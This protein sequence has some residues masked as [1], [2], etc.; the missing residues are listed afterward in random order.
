[1]DLN[2]DRARHLRST[3]S[4]TKPFTCR[5]TEIKRTN[6]VIFFYPVETGYAKAA[7]FAWA[8]I[9]EQIQVGQDRVILFSLQCSHPAL[10][11]CGP[12]MT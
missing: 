11:H 6:P 2:L 12:L 10:G 1:M 4:I 8:K 5:E 3:W 9:V 7:H